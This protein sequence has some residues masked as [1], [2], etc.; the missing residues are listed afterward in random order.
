MGTLYLL[1]LSA[2]LLAVADGAGPEWLLFVAVFAFLSLDE[3]VLGP[4]RWR[5]EEKDL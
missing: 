5:K 1:L 3:L 4:R 2:A